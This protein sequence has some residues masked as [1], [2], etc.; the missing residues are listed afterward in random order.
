MTTK[1]WLYFSIVLLAVT[2]MIQVSTIHRQKKAMQECIDGFG[3]CL[4]MGMERGN[5]P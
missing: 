2:I 4:K 5:C 1:F 3:E